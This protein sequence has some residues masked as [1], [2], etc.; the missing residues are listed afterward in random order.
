MRRITR[1]EQGGTS[2]KRALHS[3]RRTQLKL[4]ILSSVH[5]T[6]RSLC[7]ICCC[8]PEPL[9][10]SCVAAKMQNLDYISLAPALCRVFLFGRV[11][12]LSPFLACTIS[13]GSRKWPAG[14]TV[15]PGKT[16]VFLIKAPAGVFVL[17]FACIFLQ[18][19]GRCQRR[20]TCKNLY[21][22]LY[23]PRPTEN[24]RKPNILAYIAKAICHMAKMPKP[25]KT[26]DFRLYCPESVPPISGPA[27]AQFF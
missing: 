15:L 25:T 23:R 18:F 10:G 19:R 6:T 16:Y 24:L 22:F 12:P 27:N 14:W 2:W 26:Y 1:Q 9:K 4:R 17:F 3:P 21:F 5:K 20:K 13:A 8:T 7:M 11:Q